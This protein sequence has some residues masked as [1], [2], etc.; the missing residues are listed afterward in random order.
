M[1]RKE[2]NTGTFVLIALT[3]ARKM[4]IIILENISNKHVILFEAF[5]EAIDTS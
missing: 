5:E 4:Y 3:N 2:S 1:N